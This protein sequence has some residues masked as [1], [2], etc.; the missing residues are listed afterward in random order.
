MQS[1]TPIRHALFAA[2]LL[3]SPSAQAQVLGCLIEPSETVE[4]GSPVVGVVSQMLVERGDSV[5]KGQA[6]AQL[7]AAVERASYSA[8]E[9]RSQA[10]ADLRSAE[11]AE[12][13]ARTKAERTERLFE[14]QFV[15]AV[16]R[17]QAVTEHDLAK[18]RTRQSREQLRVSAQDLA[19]AGAQLGQR[20][21]RSPIDGVVVE[22][23]VSRGERVEEKPL[24]RVVA[25]DPLRVEVLM[26]ASAYNRVRVGMTA[27]VTPAAPGFGDLQTKVV[28]VDR[29]VDAAS[30]SFRVRLLLPNPDQRMPAGLRCKAAFPALDGALPPA[31]ASR[32]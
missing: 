27:V 26:P 24:M 18:A 2:F 31:V 19:V 30:N 28:L 1:I 6:L 9:A 32:P 25:L 5:R 12:T 29:V 10:E 3:S 7:S 8:A 14:Q 15:S 16:A 17:D 21:I 23:Y 4:I 13:F 22:R 11:A 20:S